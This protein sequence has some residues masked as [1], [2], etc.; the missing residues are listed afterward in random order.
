MRVAL[1][2]QI[3]KVFTMSRAPA[4]MKS[5]T[6][7]VAGGNA[8]QERQQMQQN[9]QSHM[10]S[11]M[12]TAA[13]PASLGLVGPDGRYI[14][15]TAAG[16]SGS[17]SSGPFDV[18]SQ[19]SHA[20][21]LTTDGR[22]YST[23][24]DRYHTESFKKN[25]HHNFLDSMD[26]RR[27]EKMDLASFNFNKARDGPRGFDR[28]GDPRGNY[29]RSFEDDEDDFDRDKENRFSSFSS[30]SPPRNHRPS[31]MSSVDASKNGPE[32]A[33]PLK[34][35]IDSRIIHHK[36]TSAVIDAHVKKALAH[37]TSSAK[38]P[39]SDNLLAAVS[40]NAFHLQP[41]DEQRRIVS[42]AVSDVMSK[43]SVKKHD[44]DH[45]SSRYGMARDDF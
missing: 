40:S 36:D 35:L 17:V 11:M 8:Q 37:E 13:Q 45:V 25:R 21:T 14:P 34:D 28:H 41:Q 23:P 27:A 9:Y 4:P 38:T 32:T 20:R 26:Q 1:R 6:D 19:F 3:P 22:G 7:A 12:A 29:S 33:S 39:D 30:F 24:Y 31:T 10:N 43:Y 5:S 42:K 2:P 44:P 16:V 15:A 18:D